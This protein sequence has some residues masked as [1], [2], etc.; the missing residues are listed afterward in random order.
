MHVAPAVSLDRG[1]TGAYLRRG[2]GGASLCNG[3]CRSRG[4]LSLVF[5]LLVKLFIKFWAKLLLKRLF[6]SNWYQ[7]YTRCS[8]MSPMVL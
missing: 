3:L 4:T 7:T 1:G 8:G 2:M 6:S 5:S